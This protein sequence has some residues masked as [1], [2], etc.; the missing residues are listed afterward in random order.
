[1]RCPY[2]QHY[3]TLGKDDNESP[4]I[5][6]CLKDDSGKNKKI[7]IHHS[8]FPNEQCKK[9]II[10]LEIYH[11][12]YDPFIK[13]TINQKLLYKKVIIPEETGKNFPDYIPQSLRN[14]YKEACKIVDLSPRSSATL[15]RRCLQGMIRDSFGITKGRLVDEINALQGKIDTELWQAIDAV[16]NI[17]NIAAHMEKDVNTIIDIDAGEAKELIQLIEILFEEWYI[18]R[19]ERQKRLKT[20]VDINNEKQEERKGI[21]KE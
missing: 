15:A 12:D 6:L 13:E 4:E 14:D 7:I 16:R 19:H 5:F 9:C 17:G 10:T 8:V 1:M 3:V 2:C 20:I 18:Q 21:S 11:C